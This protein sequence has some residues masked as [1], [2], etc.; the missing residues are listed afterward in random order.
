MVKGLQANFTLDYILFVG[1]VYLNAS[2][3]GIH[4]VSFSAKR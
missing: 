4:K 1:L 2:L 3:L